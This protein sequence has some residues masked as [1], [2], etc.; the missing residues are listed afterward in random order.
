MENSYRWSIL[1][2]RLCF[3]S[4]EDCSLQSVWSTGGLS[5]LTSVPLMPPSVCLLC[6]SKGQHEVQ[7]EI[8]DTPSYMSWWINLCPNSCFFIP[9][10]VLPS[11]LWTFSSLLLGTIRAAGWGEQGELVLS[12]LQVL[13]CVRPQEQTFQSWLNLFNCSKQKSSSFLSR[14]WNHMWNVLVKM[15]WMALV[16]TSCSCCL[17]WV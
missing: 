8:L 10:V 13:P 14:K 5:I 17:Q 2:T 7:T 9:D 11:V 1:R 15:F 16:F 6:A 3:S 4:Q 12:P